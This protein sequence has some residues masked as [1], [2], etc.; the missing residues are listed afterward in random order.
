MQNSWQALAKKSGEEGDGRAS[1]SH[2]SISREPVITECLLVTLPKSHF[3]RLAVRVG[4]QEE[5]NEEENE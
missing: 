5:D 1:V 4:Q 2:M 3:T